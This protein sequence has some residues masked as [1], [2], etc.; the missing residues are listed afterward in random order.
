MARQ[1]TAGFSGFKE[2]EQALDALTEPKFRAAALRA[3]GKKTMIYLEPRISD[4]CPVET[5][6]E[7]GTPGG[8]LKNSIKSSVSIGKIKTSKTGKVSKSNKHEMSARVTAGDPKNGVDYA[9]ITEYG[10]EETNIQRQ[11]VF[12]KHVAVPFDVTLPAIAPIPWMR[13]TF[14]SNKNQIILTFKD[15]LSDAITK[16]AKQQQSRIKKRNKK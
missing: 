3:A 11:T 15:E 5:N 16:K 1:T 10:R 8:R 4:A 12:G 6:V 14:D 7:S 2:L 13:T 9:I